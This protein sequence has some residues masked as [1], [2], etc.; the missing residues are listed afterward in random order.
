MTTWS[1]RH[2]VCMAAINFFSITHFSTPLHG[3]ILNTSSTSQHIPTSS[4]GTWISPIT[5]EM[6]AEGTTSTINMLIDRDTTYWCEMRPKNKGRYTIVKRDSTGNMQ[7][8]TPPDFN[9][10]SFV[11]EYG[12]GAFTVDNGLI[13]ASNAAD[14]KIYLIKPNAN[15]VPLTQG[16]VAIEH[17]GHH[18]CK[19]TRF[20]DMHVTSPGI[21][22][23]GEHH[24]PG[25]PVENFL[26]LI[27]KSTGTY[28]KIASG[29]DFYSSPAISPDEKKIAW[30]CWNH[31]NMPWTHTE[32]WLADFN[33]K[34]ELE[35]PQCI[36]GDI[37]ESIVQPQWSPDN[38]LYFVTDRD[39]GW[40]NLHRYFEGKIE[41]ICPMEAEAAEPLWIFQRSTYAFLNNHILFTFNHEGKW[42]LGILNPAT[43]EWKKL[44]RESNTIHQVRSGKGFA[45][46]LE[47]YAAKEEALIQID[48]APGLPAKILQQKKCAIEDKYISIPQHISFPSGNRTAYGFYYPPQNIDY[49]APSKEKPPLVVMIHGGPTA[50]TKGAFTL[51]RQYWTSQGFAILDVNYGGST[52]YGREYRDLLTNNWGI[53]D[54]EDCVNGAKYLVEQGFVDKNKL[55]IRGG[56][57]GGYTTLA[58]LAF[59]KTFKAGASYYGVAD[60]TAL[61]NDTHKFE[62]RYMEQLVGKYPEEKAT[63]E[64]RSPI[65]SVDQ[66]K[67]PLIIFQG[68]NDPIVPKNQ[69]IMI[70]EALKSKGIT[71]ELHIYPGE[72]HG[73]RQAIHIIHSLKREADFYREV[74]GL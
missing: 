43:K 26:A 44:K 32:L 59:Q 47:G 6:V 56:S 19:G 57:A 12:G 61:A 69:A 55:V 51:Q 41:N 42:H 25:Q 54:V 14:N 34:G 72:E 21:V 53:V 65:N 63:W 68:E 18:R 16:Q 7:D 49:R 37:P 4:Y 9:V 60:I 50:Q 33:S 3:I 13:Y 23:V 66:I 45:Q 30:I 22:A 27:D 28:K 35:N 64:S 2:L 71:V 52:G 1:L 62:Q 39:K 24:E 20:A 31:P 73:F 46:F 58:A 8:V 17:E 67:S 70:Y 11:H 29:Y 5:A 40:W 10:R 15:P 74:F 48:D 38:I 36:A